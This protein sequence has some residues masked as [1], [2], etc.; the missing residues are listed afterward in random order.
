M[1]ERKQEL[2]PVTDYTWKPK[3]LPIKE[4]AKN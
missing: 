1:I 3:G 2:E 4:Q